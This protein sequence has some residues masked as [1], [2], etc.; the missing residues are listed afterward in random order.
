MKINTEEIL[1]EIIDKMQDVMKIRANDIPNIDLY[2]D[3]VT[4][5][6]DEKLR[7]TVRKEEAQENILTKTMINNYAKNDLLPPPVKKKYSREHMMVLIFV[8]YF[9]SFLTISDIQTLLNPITEQYFGEGS[10]LKVSDIYEEILKQGAAELPK[11][12]ED[13]RTTYEAAQKTFSEVDEDDAEYLRLFAYICF[14]SYDVFVKKMLIEKL[15]DEVSE[16][17]QNREEALKKEREEQ[18]RREKEEQ[19]REKEVQ[20]REKK[21]KTVEK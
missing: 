12:E 5:F 13:M 6:M 9:K 10:E 15:L 17:R 19:K 18:L 1:N 8:Y 20:K 16:K 21:S 14:L 3:Q 2:M 7:S 4:T 11:L